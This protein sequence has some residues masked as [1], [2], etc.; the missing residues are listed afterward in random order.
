M[1]VIGVFSDIISLA[2][3][4]G[5]WLDS[6]QEK[7]TRTNYSAVQYNF[8]GPAVVHQY[9]YYYLHSYDQNGNPVYLHGCSHNVIQP[10]YEPTYQVP[11]HQQN[12]LPAAPSEYYEDDGYEELFQEEY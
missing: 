6:L 1:G 9:N 3:N 12:Y 4:L 8:F 10:A 11:V 5:E 7:P 2:N